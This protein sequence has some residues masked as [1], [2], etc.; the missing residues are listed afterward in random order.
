MSKSVIL[1]YFAQSPEQNFLNLLK[2]EYRLVKQAWLQYKDVN[3]KGYYGVDYLDSPFTKIEDIPTDIK[4]YQDSMV[5][6]HYGGHAGSKKIFLEDGVGQGSGLAGLL[7]ETKNLRLVFLNGCATHDQ[8]DALLR[9]GVKAVLAT[10]HSVPDNKAQQ[11]AATFYEELSKEGVSIQKAY[12]LARY[13]LEFEGKLPAGYTTKAT[14]WRGLDTGKKDDSPL[15]ELF[16]NPGQEAWLNNPY[17]W[18]IGNLVLSQPPSE[19]VDTPK[20]FFIYDESSRDEYKVFKDELYPRVYRG[21]LLVNGIYDIQSTLNTTAIKAEITAADVV[22]ILIR[23]NEFVG[24]W[25][26]LDLKAVNFKDKFVVF[27]RVSDPD[28]SLEV[29]TKEGIEATAT[30]PPEKWKKDMPVIGNAPPYLKKIMFSDVFTNAIEKAIDKLPGYIREFNFTTPKRK[31]EDTLKSSEKIIFA[32]IEGTQTCGHNM[33]LRNFERR[34]TEKNK[35]PRR[36]PISLKFNPFQ[37]EEG[38]EKLVSEKLGIAGNLY[39]GL[40]NLNQTEDMIIIFD[41]FLFQDNAGE[42][43][44]ETQAK[45]ILKFFTKLQ[46]ELS[47]K[48]AITILIVVVNRN[49]DGI[50]LLGLMDLPDTSNSVL[51]AIKPVECD[52]VVAWKKVIDPNGDIFEKL[53]PAKLDLTWPSHIIPTITAMGRQLLIPSKVLA[54]FF[55]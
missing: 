6:F 42:S 14:P 12:N 37:M 45:L 2:E 3:K 9:R 13:Q 29:L 25:K 31:F 23:D 8:V 5:L 16:V 24:F 35:T 46:T 54:K 20:L 32:C 19:Q 40:L 7:G 4:T 17:W 27:V 49:Y 10:N 34:L 36:V 1:S 51:Y 28:F 53:N 30:I 48:L 11:F 33:L 38:L 43:L 55:E 15:W 26:S 52:E 39:E 50:S 21:R 44:A 22:F 18:V 47:H 41:D